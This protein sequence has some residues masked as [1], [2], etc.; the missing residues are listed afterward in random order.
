MTSTLTA[1]EQLPTEHYPSEQLP[2]QQIHSM[3]PPGYYPHSAGPQWVP[4]PVA[5]PRRGLAITGLVLGV[6]GVVLALTP[7]TFWVAMPLGI[8]GLI[9]GAIGFRYGMGKAG[10]ILGGIAILISIIWAVAWGNAFDDTN[11]T[12]AAPVATVQMVNAS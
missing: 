5:Q 6:I 8:I 11:N 12:G 4:Q 9:F 3:Q 10:A 1:P 2:S 7:F